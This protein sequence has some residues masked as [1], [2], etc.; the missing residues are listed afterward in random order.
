M[1]VR[2][3]TRRLGRP[4]FH[5]IDAR[6]LNSSQRRSKEVVLGNIIQYGS[7]L[8]N[9]RA[10]RI[11][12]ALSLSSE[13]ARCTAKCT[14]KSIRYNDG[15][16]HDI[17]HTLRETRCALPISRYYL[18]DIRA[19]TYRLTGHSLAAAHAAGIYLN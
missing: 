12:L 7:R 15:H 3:G 8:E 2:L 4:C 9:D 11:A 14:T 1:G 13:H 18:T 17:S 19:L 10:A 5:T 6:P 16:Y